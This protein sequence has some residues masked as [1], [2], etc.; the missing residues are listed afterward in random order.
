MAKF[1]F[2]IVL[3]RWFK[4]NIILSVIFVMKVVDIKKAAKLRGMQTG[5]FTA[6]FL[7][8]QEQQR[9][10]LTGFMLSLAF[11]LKTGIWLNAFEK[12]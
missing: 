12:F 4:L 10:Q 3:S 6:M 1:K 5:F 9:E 7:F 11:L 8:F 2:L